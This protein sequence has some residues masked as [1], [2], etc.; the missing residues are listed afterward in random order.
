M[1]TIVAIS[2]LAITII[3]FV[4]VKIGWLKDTTALERSR[5]LMRFT[6]HHMAQLTFGR[7]TATS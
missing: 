7:S 6:M 5:I 1:G 4:A 2:L 3:L